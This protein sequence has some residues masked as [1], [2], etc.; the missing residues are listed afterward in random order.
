[1]VLDIEAVA[2]SQ[3]VH[4][5]KGL[6]ADAGAADAAVAQPVMVERLVDADDLIAAPEQAVG[7]K[8]V[9][10]QA[11][12]G[13]VQQLPDLSA[14]HLIPRNGVDRAVGGIK[15]IQQVLAA[16]YALLRGAGEVSRVAAFAVLLHI[17]DRAERH[18]GIVALAGIVQRL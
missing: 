1:M 12:F 13:V 4:S 15:L 8:V 14:V 7:H 5:I 11:A 3:S 2:V 17:L 9:L 10:M 16:E 6:R 18:I